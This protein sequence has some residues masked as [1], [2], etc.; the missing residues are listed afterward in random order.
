MTDK[1][2]IQEFFDMQTCSPKR[3]IKMKRIILNC[4]DMIGKDLD[5]LK[6]TDITKLLRK[7]NNSD[8]TQWTRNDYKKIFK[9]FIK[10]KYKDD[11]LEWME[12]NNVKDAFKCVSKKNAFNKTKISKETLITPDELEKLLRTAKSLKM[13]ALLTL[14]YESA[15]RPCELVNLKWKDC[16]FND[17][18][19]ICSIKTI[20][21]KTG[22]KRIVPVKDCIV[23]LRRWR[24]EYQYPNQN[25]EDYVFPAQRDRTKHINEVGLGVLLKRLCLQADIRPLFP[26]LF[27]HTRIYFVQKRLGARI[28]SKYAGHSLETSEIYN[29]FDDDDIEEAMLDKIYV[30]EELSEDEKSEFEKRLAD[31]E[32]KL[33]MMNETIK[34]LSDPSF[35]KFLKKYRN[36]KMT[37]K[38]IEISKIS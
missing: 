13:K 22:S 1:E 7:V 32:N 30:T 6:I 3:I 20:S 37:D 23:H 29:H 21:P 15:F 26:Y 27:R 38:F 31:Q 28:S 35:A 4:K 34:Q 33:E 9:A 24:N 2:T 19:G 25:N 11:F 5:K 16:V 36:T 10:W 17:S 8:Y 18:K 12:N 14:M